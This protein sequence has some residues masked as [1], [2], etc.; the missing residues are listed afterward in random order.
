MKQRIIVLTITAAALLSLAGCGKNGAEETQTPAAEPQ[1]TVEPLPTLKPAEPTAAP[2]TET[3]AAQPARQDGERFEAVIMLEGMEETVHYEHIRSDAVGI[4]MDY[5]YESFVRK[6]ETDRELF[7]SAWDKPENPENYLEV[8]FSASDADAAA[9][10]VSE[11]L[12]KEYKITKETFE[13]DGAGTCIRIGA[14]EVKGG[15]YMPDHLQMVYIIPAPDGCRIAAEHYAIEASEG[16]GRRFS[17]MMH[18]LTVIE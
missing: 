10:A 17:Y 12:S 5:D 15:G 8:T 13:L 18:T 7:I 11:E 9:A 4:E 14:S 3:P 1:V 16:F 6:S 2:A